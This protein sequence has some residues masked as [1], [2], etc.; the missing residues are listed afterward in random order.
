MDGLSSRC[1]PAETILGRLSMPTNVT[2]A[3]SGESPLTIQ[4]NDGTRVTINPALGGLYLADLDAGP[5]PDDYLVIANPSATATTARVTYIWANGSGLV[6]DV[7]VAA[8]SRQQ[9][10]LPTQ[11]GLNGPSS[12]AVQSL[13][14]G[15]PLDTEHV[16]AWNGW[17]AWR[18]TEGAVPAAT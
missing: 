2:I 16:Q 18:A 1:E 12:V 7:A 5:G 14:A 15:V 13:T 17:Y 8:N 3:G 10:Y 4:A 11:V 9:F 6:Q